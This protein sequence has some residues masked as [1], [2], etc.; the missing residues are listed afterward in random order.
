MN[1]P[2]GT[3]HQPRLPAGVR[4]REGFAALWD[5]LFPP[6]CLTCQVPL[7]PQRGDFLCR[8]CRGELRL[9]VAPDCLCRD[10]SIAATWSERQRACQLCKLLPESFD[11]IR[12]AFPY[13]GIVG[14][15]IRN[16][17]YRHGEAAGHAVARMTLAAL[18]EELV[19]LR[20]QGGVDVVAPVP[21][22]FARQWMRGYNQAACVAEPLAAFLG[23]EYA[24]DLVRRCRATAPQARR[25]TPQE[26][27]RNVEGAFDVPEI[28][29]AAGRGVLLVD[30]V[31]T[32]GATVASCAAALR[33]AGARA[34]HVVTVARAGARQTA[35]AP[36]QEA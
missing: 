5:F 13:A 28:D 14:E 33:L 20:D 4:L 2:P 32:T 15:L 11:S 7:D 12:S 9:F 18:G 22:Y 35:P 8:T 21:M 25:A 27:L 23:V 36:M 16:M 30:D 1:Q 34:V 24:S 10:L 26:R 17:K 29:R 6:A 31:M 3:K 19:R